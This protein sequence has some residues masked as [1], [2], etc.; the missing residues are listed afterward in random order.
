MQI[1]RFRLLLLAMF[2]LD[3]HSATVE[4]NVRL[5]KH[6]FEGYDSEIRPP[7]NHS[8]AL[9]VSVAHYLRA[10][11]EVDDVKSIFKTYGATILL[12]TDE[13]LSWEPQNYSGIEHFVSNMDSIWTPTALTLN[14]VSTAFNSDVRNYPLRVYYNGSVTMYYVD[15]M[16]T[17]FSSDMTYFPFDKQKCRIQMALAGYLPEE[18]YL[19]NYSDTVDTGVFTENNEWKLDYTVAKQIHFGAYSGMIEFQFVLTRRHLFMTINML[20]P[21]I[22]LVI[23]GPTI[24]LLPVES[25]ERVS[26]TV[27]ILLAFGVFLANIG[28]HLPE[29]SNPMSYLSYYLMICMICSSFLTMFTMFTTYIYYMEDSQTVP[30]WVMCT[31]NLL[32]LRFLK[33]VCCCTKSRRKRVHSETCKKT[34]IY[35]NDIKCTI[36]DDRA[37][38][39]ADEHM[40]WKEVARRLDNI[41]FG[42][43]WVGI[44]CLFIHCAIIVHGRP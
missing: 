31:L 43:L 1:Q 29:A 42:Y 17:S 10:I 12:W 37:R 13:R 35:G 38:I 24:L 22:M 2:L 16:E 19:V 4:E 8:H 41:A 21:V 40:T 33:A 39:N 44:A 27:T 34:S 18:V 7:R 11:V 28:D 15:V 14:A 26:F 3:A 9:A 6:L 36:E 25:G 30:T 32:S 20:T 23:V 5:R